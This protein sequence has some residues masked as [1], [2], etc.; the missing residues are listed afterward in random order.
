MTDWQSIRQRIAQM[1]AEQGRVGRT[2]S[3]HEAQ[4]ILDER[5]RMLERPQASQDA[6]AAGSEMLVFAVSG[7]RYAVGISYV[8]ETIRSTCLTAVPG[9]P[10]WFLGVESI[11]GEI[12]AVVDLDC[13]FGE[14]RPQGH[15]GAGLLIVLGQ[16]HGEFALRCDELLTVTVLS[17]ACVLH[18]PRASALGERR[19][20]VGMTNDGIR[21]IDGASLLEDERLVVEQA[22]ET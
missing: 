8:R 9:T 10:V 6:S 12:V 17:N 2:T 16:T 1:N 3:E 15:H 14:S 4:R 7:E 19:H 18:V 11:R 22:E 21:V 5:A 20:I 13:L